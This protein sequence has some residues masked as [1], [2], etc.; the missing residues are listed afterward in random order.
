MTW[1]TTNRVGEQVHYFSCVLDMTGEGGGMKKYEETKL[2]AAPSW[3]IPG[4]YLENIQ[5]L[6]EKDFIGAV[7]LLFFLYDDDISSAF[8]QEL[9][10]IR[11]FTERFVFT[12]HLPDDLN[13]GHEDLVAL[14]SPFVKHFIVHPAARARAR[15]Q[16][17]YLKKWMERYGRRRFLLENT[18]AGRLEAVLSYLDNDVPLC[19]DSAHLLIDGAS[20]ANFAETYGDRILEIHLN[21]FC[22]EVEGGAYSSHKPLRLK[23]VWLLEL[24][25]FLRSFSGIV[26]LELFSWSAV[27]QSFT[28]F[29][30]LIG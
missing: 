5:F 2:I 19:M 20:P 12:A 15:A 26:N 17:Y 11:G 18:S 13:E 29:K 25:P 7:E 24:L 22:A 6:S 8:L 21:G 27:R 23:D 3:V 9:P 16:A 4:T 10:A 28:C 30:Q 1:T 14:L